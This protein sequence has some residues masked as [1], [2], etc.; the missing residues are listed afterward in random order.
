MRLEAV[1][2][3][4]GL[5]APVKIAPS[6]QPIRL[7]RERAQSLVEFAM[8]FPILVLMLAGI[9]EIGFLYYA[10][11]TVENA[12]REGARIAVTLEDL[13][14]NDARVLDRV[15]NLIPASSFFSGFVGNTTNN[16][17]TDCDTNDEVTV[18]VSGNYNFVS[19]KLLGLTS[20]HLSFPTSMRYEL[21]E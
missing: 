5:F 6:R 15:D 19:L 16:G 17:I 4:I 10:S 20:I 7:H 2:M 21:C 3:K 8:I 14:A 18:T 12:S 9:M 1:L 13:V 11:Y